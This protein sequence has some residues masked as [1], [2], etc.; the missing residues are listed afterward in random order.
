MKKDIK[1]T[2][3]RWVIDELFPIN[4]KFTSLI[5]NKFEQTELKAMRCGDRLRENNN[6]KFHPFENKRGINIEYKV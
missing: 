2:D 6:Q 1:N 5:V 4:V 3:L